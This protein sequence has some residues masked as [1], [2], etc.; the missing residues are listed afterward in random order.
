MGIY[1]TCGMDCD[2][3][4]AILTASDGEVTGSDEHCFE[5]ADMCGWK[6]I[7]GSW[8]CALCKPCSPSATHLL[9]DG[10]QED[11]RLN[12]DD[13]NCEMGHKYLPSASNNE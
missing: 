7:L 1:K 11:L 9:C 10:H 8:Y 2:K 5:M 12:C 6:H 4:G 3:C 13:P